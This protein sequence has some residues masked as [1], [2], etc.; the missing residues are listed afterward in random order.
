M[1]FYNV[2]VYNK[3]VCY[4]GAVLLF[5]GTCLDGTKKVDNLY[6]ILGLLLSGIILV[7]WSFK[8]TKK[9]VRNDFQSGVSERTSG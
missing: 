9:A 6:L 3:P 7:L 4:I 8:K 1:N 2:N 5:A